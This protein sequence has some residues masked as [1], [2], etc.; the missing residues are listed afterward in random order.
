[1]TGK[2]C[3]RERRAIERERERERE[4]GGGGERESALF[5]FYTGGNENATSKLHA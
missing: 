4:K 5:L 2:R 3:S 1:M